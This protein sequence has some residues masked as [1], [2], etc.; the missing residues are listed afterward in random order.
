[1]MG[2]PRIRWIRTTLHDSRNYINDIDEIAKFGGDAVAIPPSEL[3]AGISR[4]K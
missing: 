1:M 4:M 3:K 2:G